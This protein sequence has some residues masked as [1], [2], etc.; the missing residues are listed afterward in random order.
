MSYQEHITKWSEEHLSKDEMTEL[1]NLWGKFD[2]NQITEY[3]Q[4]WSDFFE[5][6]QQYKHEDPTGP[7]GQEFG[8]RGWELVG[9]VW[10]KRSWFIHCQ[11]IKAAAVEQLVSV[12]RE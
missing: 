4:R 9:E 3:N 1:K 2:T 8:K 5:E 11:C 7:I 6:C 12:P 10:G